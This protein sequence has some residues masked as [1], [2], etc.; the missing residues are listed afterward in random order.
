M[1]EYARGVHWSKETSSLSFRA[2]VDHVFERLDAHL[3]SW[4]GS[5]GTD[6]G[7][8]SIVSSLIRAFW[9]S[10]RGLGS[11]FGGK[12]VS[13]HVGEP[14]FPKALRGRIEHRI[15]ACQRGFHHVAPSSEL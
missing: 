12:A 4:L 5:A 11:E 10:D 8:K 13:I 14:E 9:I 2:V 7:Q 3:L 15:L 6:S 1:A